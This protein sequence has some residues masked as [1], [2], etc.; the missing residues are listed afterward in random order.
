VA[1]VAQ[2]AV[3]WVCGK[4][5]WRQ[6]VKFADASDKREIERIVLSAW[7]ARS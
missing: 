1:C 3:D 7:K 2:H 6:H 5:R 4:Q